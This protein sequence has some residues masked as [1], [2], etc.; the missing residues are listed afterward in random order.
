MDSSHATVTDFSVAASK[1]RESALLRAAANGDRDAY[2]EIYH[3]H[4][5]RV[6]ALC[7]RLTGERSMAED[8]DNTALLGMLQHIYQ[9][10]LLLIER[11][12]APRWQHI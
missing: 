8:A 12:H 7:F 1:M 11:V 4:I 9:Q 5:N 10:Q 6:Y 2:R 3:A